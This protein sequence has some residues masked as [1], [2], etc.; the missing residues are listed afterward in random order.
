MLYLH[1]KEGENK[2][3][4]SLLVQH[5]VGDPINIPFRWVHQVWN[6]QACVKFAW[7]LYKLENMKTII[8]SNHMGRNII[9][10]A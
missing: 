3:G 8:Q 2:L 10:N 4:Y 9:A 7:D 1:L 6:L 5:F